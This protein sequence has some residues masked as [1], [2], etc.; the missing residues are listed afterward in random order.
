MPRPYPRNSDLVDLN[1]YFFV[2]FILV[3]NDYPGIP[4]VKTETVG[5]ILKV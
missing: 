1:S 2:I 5:C 4:G 3:A